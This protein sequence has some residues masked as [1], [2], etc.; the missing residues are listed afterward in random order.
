M[1]A[2]KLTRNEE[3][4]TINIIHF[5]FAA[6]FATLRNNF[7]IEIAQGGRNHYGKRQEAGVNGTGS[8][9]FRPTC[10]PPPQPPPIYERVHPAHHKFE[11]A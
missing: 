7:A 4:C 8:G 2:I 5:C 3:D 11:N 9:R 1:A 10:P 6:P